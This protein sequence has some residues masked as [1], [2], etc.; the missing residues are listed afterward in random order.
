MFKRQTGVALIAALCSTIALADEVI[1]IGHA[2]PLTGPSARV[3]KDTENGALLAIEDA[4]AKGI[5]IGGQKVKF[6]LVGV[7]DQADPRQGVIAAQRLVDMGVKAVI[8]HQ[9][10][11]TSIP[12][13]K[14]Y[15]DAGIPQVSPSATNVKLT[16]QGYKAV[17]RVVGNDNQQG[18][19]LV[20]YAVKTLKAKTVAVIDDRT[21]YGQGLADVV[22]REA[23]RQ[24]AKVVA[25]EFGTDKT[26]D[27][28]PILTKLKALK[29]DAVIY[30]GMDATAAPLVK[31]GRQLG[32]PAKF[33]FGDGA[34]SSDMLKLAAG[35]LSGDTFCT[36]AGLPTEFMP[37]GRNFMKRFKTR[38]GVDVN[39]NA[40][41]SYDATNAIILAMQHANSV[42]PAKYLP[43]LKTQRFDGVT[44]P[45]EFD[46]N[47]DLKQAAITVYGFQKESW[48]KVDV[49][50]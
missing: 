6:E 3:G 33:L 34:C 45:V 31:Q 21:A 7:D 48:V 38:F 41:F 43:V 40:P 13:S 30:G 1:K 18:A 29:P 26:T 17:F 28:L 11:G 8:G 9:S 46:A 22:E 20:S 35:A 19:A 39:L 42:D 4:N 15:N 37:M 10:S 32:I 24:G 5:K 50:R 12:A 36:I 25:H 23:A 16:H 49:I 44:G 47:G 2:A 27:W 14:V